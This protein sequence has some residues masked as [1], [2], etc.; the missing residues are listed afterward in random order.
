MKT[1]YNPKKGISVFASHVSRAD[2]RTVHIQN[3]PDMIGVPPRDVIERA[4]AGTCFRLLTDEELEK[5]GM[6]WVGADGF[7]IDF[8]SADK[9]NLFD[10]VEN[11]RSCCGKGEIYADN[12]GIALVERIGRDSG[13]RLGID[14]NMR[15]I[16]VERDVSDI[17]TRLYPYG[18]DDLH[19]GSVNGGRQYVDSA[20]IALYGVREGYRDYGEFTEPEKLLARAEWELSA[21]NP[22][23]LDAP[24]VNVS[25]SV[26]DLGKLAEYGDAEKLEIG[27]GVTVIDRGR[28]IYERVIRLERYPFE[29][30]PTEITLGALKRDLFFYLSQMGRLG[31]NY[32]RVSTADGRVRSDC[33]SGEVRVGGISTDAQG[34][35]TFSGNVNAKTIN[36]LSAEVKD[37]ELY[38]GGRRVVTE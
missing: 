15:G 6:E 11:V 17:V 26:I 19:I 21:N 8:F 9:L 20:D 35:S 5:R 10:A 38:I 32:R 25:G 28:A 16:E 2:A 12:Y 13:V 31:A 1:S 24:R 37:G 3:I 36:G 29:P 22:E 30:S 33:I 27:D 14:R 18:K 34:V 4:A 7:L 23:R